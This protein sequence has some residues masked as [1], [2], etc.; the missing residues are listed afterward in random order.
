MFPRSLRSAEVIIKAT[1][2][3][4][5]S[6]GWFVTEEGCFGI[7]PKNFKPGDGV[8]EVQHCNIMM[9]FRQS[10]SDSTPISVTLVGGSYAPG[11]GDEFDKNPKGK[12]EEFFIV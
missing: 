2:S 4:F 7:R 8:Y 10:E 3:H 9:A 6:L 11:L 1:L 12:F 5:R